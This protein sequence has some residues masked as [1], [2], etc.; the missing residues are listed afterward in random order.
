MYIDCSILRFT[1][2]P[3]FGEPKVK[4]L[5]AIA[6]HGSGNREY[7]QQLLSTYNRMPFDTHVVVLSNKPK[8]LGPKA[9][10]VVGVPSS[11]PWSLPF[12]HR[13]LFKRL[14]DDYDYFI[15][16][17]DD[18]LM[19]EKVLSNVMKSEAELG[20]AEIAGFMRTE[21]GPGGE[22]FY[23]TAH[24]FFRWLPGSVRERGGR[25]WARY[26]NEHA[27]CFVASRRQLKLAIESGGFG[28]E[29]HEGRHD[30]LCAAATDIY[31]QCG[32][33]R[34]VCI[35]DL[36]DFSLKHL[37]NKYIGRMGLPSAEMLWQL[38]ALRRVHAGELGADELLDPETKLPGCYGSKSCRERPD[39]ML[40]EMVG[41]EKRRVLVWCS[42]DGVAE[43]DLAHRGHEVTVQPSD[44]VLGACCERRGLRVL[45]P[46][47]A[48][49]AEEKG[50]HDVALIRDALH[51]VSDPAATLRE[52]SAGLVSGGRVIVRVPNLNN[53][54]TLRRRVQNPRFRMKWNRESIGAIPFTPASLKRAMCEA[55]LLDITVQA[56][57]P[58]QRKKYLYATAG[59]AR[60][61]L[62]PH[63]YAVGVRG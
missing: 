31:T 59:A 32:L 9:E 3:S 61:Q 54:S 17:E 22:M 28:D 40:V 36:P 38:E 39:P 53:L 34:L 10:V 23:S 11:N 50:Q 16:S 27:A 21:T 26:S 12:A 7:L 55:G 6:N 37:P 45:P 18:T 29:P 24:S 41:R 60:F 35:D 58:P 46:V 47:L 25:L 5:V 43:A 14:V 51:L 42:G 44:A 15:Y 48:A 56:V 8:D 30:M 33:E 49:L 4:V 13:P 2:I 1:I 52:V 19:P 63:L 57:V 62:S 20:P